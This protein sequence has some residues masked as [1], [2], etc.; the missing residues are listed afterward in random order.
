MKNFDM[1]H[2]SLSIRRSLVLAWARVLGHEW[3]GIHVHT[4]AHSLHSFDYDSVS[5]VQPAGDDPS[6]IDPVAD[7]D[8]SNIHFVVGVN[9]SDLVAALQF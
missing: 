9:D 3:L 6:V 1:G 4:G 5:G 8:G 7:G 2:P